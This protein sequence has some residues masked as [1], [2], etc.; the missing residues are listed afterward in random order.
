MIPSLS[1]ITTGMLVPSTT[2]TNLFPPTLKSSLS[3]LS[4]PMKVLLSVENPSFDPW[5]N[6]ILPL[7]VKLVSFNNCKLSLL[8]LPVITWE[9]AL[10]CANSRIPSSVP[11]LASNILPVIFA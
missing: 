1:I 10:M 5:S 7:T 9:P 3:T 2:E 4:C 6:V 11:L 8:N